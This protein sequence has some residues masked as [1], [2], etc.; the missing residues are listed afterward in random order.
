MLK[1]VRYSF[2]GGG[3]SKRDG[4]LS[5]VEYIRTESVSQSNTFEIHEYRRYTFDKHITLSGTMQSKEI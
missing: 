4:V 1:P 3:K 5:A 2:F